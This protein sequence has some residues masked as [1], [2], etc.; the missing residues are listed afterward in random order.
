MLSSTLILNPENNLIN[1]LSRTSSFP[2]IKV[3]TFDH[4]IA[5]LAEHNQ[6]RKTD[7]QQGSESR[8]IRSKKTKEEK[9][10]TGPVRNEIPLRATREQAGSD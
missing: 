1:L 3:L 8:E 7:N 10:T 4:D 9:T 2:L 6:Q 5:S